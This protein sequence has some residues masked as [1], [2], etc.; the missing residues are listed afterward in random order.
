VER[1]ANGSTGWAQ[2]A[3]TTVGTTTYSDTGLSAGTSY[4]YRV[5]ATAGSSG[6]AYS[7]IVSATT[8]SNSTTGSTDTI[9]SNSYQ[10]QINAYSSGNYE[11]GVKFTSDV[12]GNVTGARFFKQTWMNGYSH[13]GHLWSSSGAL[14]ATAAFTSETASGWEQVKFRDTSVDL[15]EYDLYDLVLVRRRLLRNQHDILRDRGR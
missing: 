12:S 9:W 11:L 14:L 8:T 1:S 6:S 4:Y 7:N 5:R 15:G 3:T 10:P 13:V 2:V